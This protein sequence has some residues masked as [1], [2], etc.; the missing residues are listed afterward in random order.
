MTIEEYLKRHIRYNHLISKEEIIDKLYNL[1]YPANFVS[2]GTQTSAEGEEEEYHKDEVAVEQDHDEQEHDEQEQ[3][4]HGQREQKGQGRAHSPRGLLYRAWRQ[5][6]PGQ[7]SQAGALRVN[8][9]DLLST[10][11][12]LH[13]HERPRDHNLLS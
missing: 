4:R 8:S 13:R 11:Q 9:R 7:T 12:H 1:H 10:I 2:V 3:G 5:L 6:G